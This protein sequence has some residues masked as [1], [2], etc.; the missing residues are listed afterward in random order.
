MLTHY[1]D[2]KG[3]AKCRNWSALVCVGLGSLMCHGL[4]TLDVGC[5]GTDE[6]QVLLIMK[7]FNKIL[8]KH[9]NHNLT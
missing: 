5:E 4:E 7:V 3:S 2:M 1:H 8:I 6:I 9:T